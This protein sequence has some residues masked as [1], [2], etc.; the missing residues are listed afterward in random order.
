MFT[1]HKR[2][3]WIMAGI[4]SL[5]LT[6]TLAQRA[7]AVTGN[8][9]FHVQLTQNNVEGYEWP[10][11]ASVT[12]TIDDPANGA[13]TDF[14]DTVT[15][16]SGGTARFDDVGGI[17][18]A[19]GV[20]V[21]MNDGTTY[22]DHTVTILALT[23]VN[24]ASDTVSGTTTSGNF[25]NTWVECSPGNT[26]T[27]YVWADGG[28]NW[29]ADYSVVGIQPEEQTTCD[30]QPGSHGEVMEPDAEADHTDIDWSIPDPKFSAHPQEDTLHGFEWPLGATMTIEIDDPAVPGSPDF[31]DT[32]TVVAA[33]WDPNQTYF[34]I[35][36]GPA[37]DLKPGDTVSVTDGSTT[38]THTVRD[39]VITDADP[40]TDTVAGS[41][42]DSAD[43]YTEICDPFGCTPRNETPDGGGN[44]LA[45]FSV[46]GNEPNEQNT[47]DLQPGTSGN[48]IQWDG[49][50]DETLVSWRIP[51]PRIGVRPRTQNVE[52]WEW[53]LGATVTIEIDDPLTPANPDAGD[54]TIVIA[55][56]WNPSETWFNAEFFGVYLI[57]PGDVVTASDGTT[58]KS[59]TV[60][61]YQI[62]AINDGADTVSGAANPGSIVDLWVCDPGGC[63]NR[64]ETAGGGGTWSAN[65]GA[66]G[67]QD[68]EQTTYDIVPG[69]EG[70]SGQWDAEQDGTMIWWGQ[71]PFGFDKSAPSN[72]ALNQP[73]NVTLIWDTAPNALS[74]EYCIDTTNDNACST[75]VSTGAVTNVTLNGLTRGATY[76]WQARALNETGIT[77]ANGDAAAFWSFRI[78]NAPAEF[79]KIAPAN[80][81]TDRPVSVTVSWA[82]S[83][84][85]TSYEVCY[86]TINNGACDG[87]WISNGAST[88]RILNNL[89]A[90]T[91]YYW[92]ARAKNI[93]GFTY[94]NGGAPG[95]WSFTTGLLPGGFTKATPLNGATNQVTVLNLTWNAASNAD[96][97]AY[98]MDT[99]NDNNCSNWINVGANTSAAIGPLAPNT[100]YYWHVRAANAIGVTY[101]NGAMTAFWNFRTGAAPGNFNKSS[102]GNGALNQPTNVT[103]IWGS[104]PGAVSYEYCYDTLNNSVCDT[105]WVSNGLATGVPL[106][107]LSMG[108]TYYWQARAI[109]PIGT[110]YANGAVSS[111]WSFTTGA[112]PAAFVKTQPSNPSELGSTSTTLKWTASAGAALYEYCIDTTN[113]NACST[114][115]L[116]NGSSTQKSLSGLT[117]NTVYYWHVRANNAFGQTYSN[118]DPA[119]FWSFVIHLPPS[120]PGLA[121]PA[122]NALVTNPNV[123]FNWNNSRVPRGAVFSHYQLQVATDIGFL[124][125]VADTNIGGITNS[126]KTLLLP[127]G[128]GYYWRVRA[129]NTAGEFSAWSVVRYVKVAYA[130][131]ALLTP[132]N[133]STV[134]SLTPSFDW[135]DVPGAITYTIQVSRS[136][137]FGF[138]VSTYSS[139]VS[140]F[141]LGS[142]LLAHTTY[143]WRVRVE[144]PFGPGAWSAV[145]RFSTP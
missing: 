122:D 80:S 66:P 120:T 34:Y 119:A 23:S 136:L 138:G 15:A 107:G 81:T 4:L 132:V 57:K 100:T 64:T 86:D 50:H 125:I 82:A 108:T 74:Y 143:Y 117:P 46:F 88:S 71:S 58:T 20:Y 89:N 139:G 94:A 75:W 127:T 33:P 135:S 17:D 53:P 16:D 87:A 35:E 95:F 93:Y 105:G 144:G 104:S 103:L 79:D 77:Y 70:D 76:Y 114:S 113:D 97:Y 56:P 28:G 72:G 5:A 102:P 40:L 106:S 65:F 48:T 62:T 124:S 63:V 130:P 99:S 84:G 47:Y 8:E 67:D 51:N 29:T 137:S 27:R 129:W 24:Q 55:A 121:S 18:L 44:F 134:G 31:S 12:M 14:T 110:T 61:N 140:N 90:G 10:V 2:F 73:T 115:W 45:D 42:D 116:A 91:T 25:V 128:A 118:G 32:T 49:D 41:T 126:Q 112:P 145:F 83:N 3:T 43:I 141:T 1:N 98:C 85:A 22:K 101:S 13:G 52:G 36:A 68:W 111:F 21:A 131:P 133:G 60:T 54:S 7:G 11:G 38:K 142:P 9:R 123:N 96:F 78:T 19:A 109:N 26:A 37:Y 59:T 30:I 69:T 6:L 92:Q 39:I